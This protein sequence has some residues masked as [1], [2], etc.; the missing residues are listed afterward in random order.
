M[1]VYVGMIC[2]KDLFLFPGYSK[3][4]KCEAHAG[5]GNSCRALAY[6][7]SALKISIDVFSAFRPEIAI[8]Y[9][10]MSPNIR[11]NQIHE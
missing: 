6:C 5:M 4:A 2:V 1:D 9:R 8:K 10:K 3:Y 11:K 7:F